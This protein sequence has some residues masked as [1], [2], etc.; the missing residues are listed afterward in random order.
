MYVNLVF[1]VY[2]NYVFELPRIG[3]QY[4]IFLNSPKLYKGTNNNRFR[5]DLNPKF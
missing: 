2:K 4:L 1:S 5:Q 3:L